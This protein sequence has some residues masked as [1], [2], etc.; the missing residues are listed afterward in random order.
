MDKGPCISCAKVCVHDECNCER[1]VFDPASAG[2]KG[3]YLEVY[4][5]YVMCV[6]TVDWLGLCEAYST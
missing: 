6:W 4:D 5:H 2:S 3:M 1:V